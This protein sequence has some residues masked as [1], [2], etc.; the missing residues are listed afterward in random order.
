MTE[1]YYFL[2][3]RRHVIKPMI[4]RKSNVH[5]KSV[6]C[7]IHHSNDGSMDTICADGEREEGTD[8][9]RR[10][11]CLVVHCCE[12]LFAIF[13]FVLFINKRLV[14]ASELSKIPESFFLLLVQ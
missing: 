7:V 14:D 9:R 4:G 8:R 3:S 2:L 6:L 5:I 11:R 1:N 13:S 12:F 10:R